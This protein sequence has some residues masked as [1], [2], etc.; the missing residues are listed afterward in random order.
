MLELPPC[1]VGALGFSSYHRI[2]FVFYLQD[3]IELS[4]LVTEFSVLVCVSI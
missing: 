3:L 1:H 2:T 4:Q